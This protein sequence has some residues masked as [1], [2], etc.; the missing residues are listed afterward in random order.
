MKS[1]TALRLSLKNVGELKKLVER[2]EADDN[3]DP[4]ALERLRQRLAEAQE[5][6]EASR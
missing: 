6:V 1:E 2:C 5:A 3:Y 4:E